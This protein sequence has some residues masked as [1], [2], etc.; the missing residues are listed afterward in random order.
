MVLVL[1]KGM[2]VKD[3]LIVIR[4]ALLVFDCFAWKNHAFFLDN[5]LFFGLL[6]VESL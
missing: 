1:W 2:K 3:C 5:L 4:E 6:L